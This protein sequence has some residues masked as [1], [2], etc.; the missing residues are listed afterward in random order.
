MYSKLI[1][2]ILKDIDLKGSIQNWKE[3]KELHNLF[4]NSNKLKL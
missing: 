3:M 1:T 4:Q 2:I